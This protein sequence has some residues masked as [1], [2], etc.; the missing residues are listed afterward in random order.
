MI[1]ISI[2]NELAAEHPEFMAGCAERGHRVEVFGEATAGSTVGDGR[3]DGVGLKADEA[4]AW[5]RAAKPG[6]G[7][8]Q[9]PH[10]RSLRA[11]NSALFL[12]A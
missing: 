4:R 3:P 8:T 7:G 2:S 10:R 12:R 6:S 9:Q 11:S 5:R 1:K